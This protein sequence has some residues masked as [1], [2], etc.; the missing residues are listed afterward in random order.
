MS[1]RTVQIIELRLS[2][3]SEPYQQ[4]LMKLLNG[5]WGGVLQILS[6]STDMHS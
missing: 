1:R 4:S 3:I 6:V 2:R 5:P